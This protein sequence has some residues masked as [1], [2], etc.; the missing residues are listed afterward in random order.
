MVVLH[1]HQK[2]NIFYQH[3]ILSMVVLHRH[4]KLNIFYPHSTLSM[5]V[6]HR[7]Q[8]LNIFYPHSTLSMVVLQLS[9]ARVTFSPTRCPLHDKSFSQHLYIAPV[10]RREKSLRQKSS[11]ILS[12]VKIIAPSSGEKTGD[13]YSFVVIRESSVSTYYVR[14]IG[15]RNCS[16]EKGLIFK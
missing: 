15:G 11:A 14:A 8:K 2:L 6:L 3:I 7:H 10:L 13:S 1:R 4:Q 12:Y 9:L 5:V 16:S